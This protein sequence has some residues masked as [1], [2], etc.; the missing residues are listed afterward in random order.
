MIDPEIRQASEIKLIGISKQVRINDP[1]TVEIWKSFVPRR[2]E[3]KNRVDQNLYSVHIYDH[4]FKPENVTPQTIVTRYASVQVDSF[5]NI[6]DGMETLTIPA[7]VWAVFTFKGTP[8][9]FPE[10]WMQ[11]MFEWLPSS[12]YQLD[13]RPHFEMLGNKYKH[14]D[15][16]SEEEVWIPVRK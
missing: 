3:V 14:N 2:D 9:Q 6:P 8:Q 7:G 5:S 1:A 16:E 12:S 10:T 4:D 13:S 11:F 15:P